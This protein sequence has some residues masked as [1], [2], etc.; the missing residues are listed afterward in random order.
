VAWLRSTYSTPN[1]VFGVKMLFE[2]FEN[3]S[4]FSAVQKLFKDAIILRLSRRRKLAQAVS[5]LMAVETG[6]WIAS[7]P[8][9]KRPEDVSY[10]FARIQH[11]MEMLVR[12]DARWDAI[13]DSF[14]KPAI[15][16]TFEEFIT[17]PRAH[18]N[19]L[20]EAIGVDLGSKELT[21]G[22]VPQATARSHE[23]AAQFRSEF[24]AQLPD[25]KRLSYGGVAFAP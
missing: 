6:Q 4:T 9:R 18:V 14:G 17:N 16:W 19:E 21:T 25:A 7:D 22:L 10:D 11:Y 12:Q 8:P 2:D 5:Y 20:A 1:G 15:N 23:L 3:L 24:A 13:L